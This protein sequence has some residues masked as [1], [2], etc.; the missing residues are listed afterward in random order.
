MSV[1][2]CG[3]LEHETTCLCDVY[4]TEAKPISVTIPYD[5]LGG[6]GV[7]RAL[8]LGVPWTSG[9]LASF[10][11]ALGRGYEALAKER[12]DEAST[13]RKMNEYHLECLKDYI[14]EGIMPTPIVGMMKSRF[15]VDITRSYVCHT[16][17]RMR[18]R[19][20]M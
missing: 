12:R 10:F 2:D 18:A 6:E 3:V 4:V 16:R 5:I 14:R 15:D 17:T 1:N 8:N 7:A 20:E 9:D 13:M 19:G 11:E